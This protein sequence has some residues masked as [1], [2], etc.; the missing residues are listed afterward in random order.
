MLFSFFPEEDC[1]IG[2]TTLSGHHLDLSNDI[3]RVPLGDDPLGLV[4]VDDQAA[5]ILELGI[6]EAEVAL[7]FLQVFELVIVVRSIHSIMAAAQ[8]EK[9]NDASFAKARQHSEDGLV[10]RGEIEGPLRV[11][12]EL[13]LPTGGF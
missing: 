12:G 4:F 1:G 8:D 10:R 2:A 6:A 9:A 3:C 7:D 11:D 13:I 5:E